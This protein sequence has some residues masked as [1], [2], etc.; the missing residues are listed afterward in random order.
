[1]TIYR[2]FFL[3]SYVAAA[4]GVMK[5]ILSG[6]L[7]GY[8]H[9]SLQIFAAVVSDIGVAPSL[10]MTPSK[11]PAIEVFVPPLVPGVIILVLAFLLE[12][13]VYG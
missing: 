6:G 10:D 5:K 9:Q 13:V 3:S 8:D 7:H 1:M 4:H 2:D 11:V 12:L